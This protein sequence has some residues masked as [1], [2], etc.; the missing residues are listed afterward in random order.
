MRARPSFGGR[1]GLGPPSQISDLVQR[2]RRAI[3]AGRYHRSI[4]SPRACSLIASVYRIRLFFL[5]AP[6]RGVYAGLFK[7]GAAESGMGGL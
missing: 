2:D 4:D 7:G 6:T 5:R 1:D 3:D